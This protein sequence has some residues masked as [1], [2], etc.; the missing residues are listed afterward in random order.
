MIAADKFRLLEYLGHFRMGTAAVAACSVGVGIAIAFAAAN[1]R[2]LVGALGAAILASLLFFPEF[3]LALYVV[4]GDVKG[5]DRVAALL[6]FDWTVALGAVLVAGI[7]L[8]VL[9]GR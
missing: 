6:P 4:V 1:P 2:L 7:L 5:D 3:A 9:R 8:N